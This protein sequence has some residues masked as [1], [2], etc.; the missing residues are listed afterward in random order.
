MQMSFKKIFVLFFVSV[1]ISEFAFAQDIPVKKDS[2]QL[3]KNI[4]TYSGKKKLTKFMFGLFFRPVANVKPQSK[5]KVMVYKK[6]IQKPYSAYEGKIIRQINIE[7]HDPF[8]YS[9]Y[10]TIATKSNFLPTTGNKLHIKTQSITI[11]N[12]LLIHRNQVFDSLLVKESERLVRSRGYVTDVTFTVLSSSEKSD[13]VDIY[14]RELDKWSIVPKAIFSSSRNSINLTDK[15]FLGLGHE[16]QNVFTRNFSNSINTFSTNYT[17]PNLRNTYIS[18]TLHYEIDGYQNFTRSLTVERPFYSPLANW[19][20]GAF[21]ATQFKQDSLKVVDSGYVPL[22][23]KFDTQDYWVAKAF[24]IFKGNSVDER[25]TNLIIATRFLRIR[26]YKKPTEI[27]DPLHV[28]S[29]EDF[30]LAGIGISSRRYVQDKFIYKYG[31]IEDV[32]VGKVYSLTAGYQIKNKIVRPYFGIRFSYGNYNEWGYLSTNFEF[33]T[34]VNAGKVEQGVITAGVSYFTGLFEIGQWKF[35]QFVKPEVTIG[36]NRYYNDSLTLKDSY[37]LHGFNSSDLSGSKRILFSF[38]TQTYSPWEVLGFH[39]GPYLICSLGVL[40]DGPKGF[41]NSK[42]Y[43][44]IGIGVL[45]KNENLIINTFQFSISFYPLI[46][47]NGQDIFKINSFSTTD[48]GLRDFEI[49]K[50]AIVIFR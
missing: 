2:T 11:R 35:R 48:F 7:T 30:Y 40:G 36:L 6:L 31:V 3:Y 38:Q 42:I 49:G 25:T 18:T 44:Q 46:P 20:A 23:L 26:Y 22:N 14:I 24:R 34:F 4:E 13:S 50:P 21:L 47:G 41:R 8:G 15:N 29:N 17:I 19:A 45:I 10:D 5:N 27:Y 28:Y 37:G 9:I 16:Y 39:F 33:G 43:S 12:L 1:F 32:P